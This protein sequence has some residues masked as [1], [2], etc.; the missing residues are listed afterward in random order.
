[1]THTPHNEVTGSSVAA[2]WMSRGECGERDSYSYLFQRVDYQPLASLV[3]QASESGRSREIESLIC[4]FCLSVAER[5][6]VLA[7]PSLRSTKILL[8]R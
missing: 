5:S 3:V 4:N 2:V 7:D 8:R 6:I 1:M